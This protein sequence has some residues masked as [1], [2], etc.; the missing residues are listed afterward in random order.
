[1]FDSNKLK[2][3]ILQKCENKGYKS[4]WDFIKKDED[5]QRDVIWLYLYTGKHQKSFKKER[6]YCKDF[7]MELFAPF[8]I[9]ITDAWTIGDH[10]LGAK[11]ENKESFSYAGMIDMGERDLESS[12]AIALR[13]EHF[14]FY[15]K[16][17]T[18][19][20]FPY[21]WFIVAW[22]VSILLIAH[23]C[24]E[25][26]L[27]YMVGFYGFFG[28]MK[29]NSSAVLIGNAV[30]AGLCILGLFYCICS[31]YFDYSSN[32]NG[33]F[34]I[35]VVAA[36]FLVIGLLSLFYETKLTCILGSGWKTTNRIRIG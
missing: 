10:V 35:I 32:I 16:F 33:Y 3:R 5:L 7:M 12:S 1:M 13:R 23:F 19:K 4:M 21:V 11:I 24:P 27:L 22:I 15:D 2:D 20:H 17:T 14:N 6:E 26:K 36:A 9:N 29:N 31:D 18:W 30:C 28:L 8:R 34:G 25:Y